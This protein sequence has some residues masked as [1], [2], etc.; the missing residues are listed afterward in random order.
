MPRSATYT[1]LD[2]NPAGWLKARSLPVRVAVVAGCV[3]ALSVI[4]YAEVP[5]VPVPVT[6]QTLGVTLAG[7]LFGWR[8]GALAVALWLLA[9]ALG[10]PVLS[11]GGSGYRHFLGPTAGYLFAFPLAAMLTGWLAE[12]GWTGEAMTMALLS[13]LAGNG[14]CLLIGWA[15]LAAG[16]GM[17]Q[18]FI[19]GVAPFLIG[20]GLKAAFGA[21]LLRALAGLMQHRQQRRL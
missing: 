19:H 3:V 5:M 20:A 17:E 6:L 12:R 7:A 15:W 11:G 16:I 14:L 10:L 1:A 13:M 4:S 18:A 8:R 21:A 9:G 2:F